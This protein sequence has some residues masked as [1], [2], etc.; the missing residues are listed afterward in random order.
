MITMRMRPM[1]I[2]GLMV[3]FAGGCARTV[4]KQDIPVTTNPMGAMIYTNGQLMGATPGTVSL[5]RNRNH[6]LTLIKENYRQ[7]DV[8]ITKQ[9][10]KDR[11]YLKAIQSGVN[12]GLF[13]K[14]PAMGINSGMDSISAQEETGEAY[15]L[16]PPAVKVDL[17]P[18]SGFF[19]EPNHRGTAAPAARE[20][21]IRNP[22][23]RVRPRRPPWKGANW[24][25]R[26]SRSAPARRSAR[27]V[28]SRRRWRPRL[29]PSVCHPRRDEGTG[30][31]EHFG[32][33]RHQPRRTGRYHRRACLNDVC[34]NELRR[35][36]AAPKSPR[37]EAVMKRVVNMILGMCWAS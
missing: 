35:G 20:T 31:D 30:E 5:E 1:M 7:E 9:Y 12:S 16:S 36:A 14:N 22:G 27:P 26:S 28:R 18:L 29:P 23:R 13:F 8:I 15:V 25:K 17:K 2:L 33:G 34:L 10:Q 6:I 3:L 4:L 24:P 37:K 32:R 11:V 21:V 19:F